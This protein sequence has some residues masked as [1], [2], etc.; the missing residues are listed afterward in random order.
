[1]PEDEAVAAIVQDFGVPELRARM[2]LSIMK[3]ERPDGDVVRLQ[4]TA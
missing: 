4:D 3:G 2:I 1:M